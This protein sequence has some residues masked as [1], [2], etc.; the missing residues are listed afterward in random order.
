MDTSGVDG[1][2]AKFKLAQ[3]SVTANSILIKDCK[4][5]QGGLACA[6]TL[7]VVLQ[8]AAAVKVAAADSARFPAFNW[9]KR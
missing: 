7:H 9:P 2:G 8:D 6:A 1:G 5:Q 3:V 4:P